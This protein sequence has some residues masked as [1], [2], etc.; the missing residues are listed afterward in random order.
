MDICDYT[1]SAAEIFNNIIFTEKVANIIKQAHLKAAELTNTNGG[2]ALTAFHIRAGDAVYPFAD[3][4]KM[5][6]VNFHPT[7]IELAYEIIKDLAKETKVIIFSDD[8][9]S[10]EELKRV[11][12]SK[13][14]FLAEEFRDYHQFSNTELFLFD[15]VLMSH[16][17]KIYGTHSAVA[18]FAA[19]IGG[20]ELINPHTIY[21]ANKIYQ[22]YKE[23][24]GKLDLH[25]AHKAQTLFYTYLAARA[26]GEEFEKLISLL[27]QALK[28][29]YENDKYRI[30]ILDTLI[31]NNEFKR[32]DEYLGQILQT[33]KDKFLELFFTDNE[34]ANC[35]EMLLKYCFINTRKFKNLDLIAK[36]ARQL[37][38]CKD[39][40][41]EKKLRKLRLYLPQRHLWFKK[42]F[43]RH[44]NRYL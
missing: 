23:N 3:F 8:I 28:Y 44:Y 34:W 31:C 22:I 1:Q 33:R 13:N 42:Y 43:K 26:S 24:F 6:C 21:P 38:Y 25:D 10:V 7:P 15:T 17:K 30:Y 18:N 37:P 27:E 4:R 11:L 32:A 2:G 29:D 35:K 16:A 5:P 14:I 20:V 41:K 36:R 12:N 40:F 39:F 19:T 9:N